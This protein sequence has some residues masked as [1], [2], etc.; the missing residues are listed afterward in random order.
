MWI[1]R[2]NGFYFSGGGI[3]LPLLWACAQFVQALLGPGAFRLQVPALP[4][5]PPLFGIQF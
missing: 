1:Y 4:G 2:R 3:E 5:L